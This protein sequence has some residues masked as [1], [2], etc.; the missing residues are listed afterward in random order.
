MLA[1]AAWRSR[2]ADARIELRQMD[3]TH[4]DFPTASFDA[5]VATFLFCVLADDLQVPALRELGR[6]VRSGGTIRLL[7]YVRPHGRLRRLS[8]ALWEPWMAWAY[9]A[10]FDRNT[11]RHV[12]EAGLELIDAHFVVHDLMQLLTV[13]VRV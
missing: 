6:V 11:A 9:G 7:E 8:A 13:R 5:A 10:S 4:L 1:R 12:P 3:V 2:Q